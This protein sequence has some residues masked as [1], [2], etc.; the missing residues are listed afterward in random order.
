MQNVRPCRMSRPPRLCLLGKLFKEDF[1]L[2]LSVFFGPCTPYQYRIHGPGQW[3]G[4]R[5]AIMTQWDRV[6]APFKT[7]PVP[8]DNSSNIARRLLLLVVS[9]LVVYLAIRFCC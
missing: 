9:L 1:R 8:A 2:A 3:A 6:Y 4:A 5:D 7:R